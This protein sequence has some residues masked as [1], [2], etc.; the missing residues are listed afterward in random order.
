ME[1]ELVPVTKDKTER[2]RRSKTWILKS[3]KGLPV[4]LCL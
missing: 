2:S 1:L 3:E 4:E